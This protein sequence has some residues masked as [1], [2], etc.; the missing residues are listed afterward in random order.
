ML[1]NVKVKQAC[2]RTMQ[3]HIGLHLM[4][5]NLEINSNSR[6]TGKMARQMKWVMRLHEAILKTGPAAIAVTMPFKETVKR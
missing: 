6:P 2:G 5:F 3:R 1:Q 4:Y